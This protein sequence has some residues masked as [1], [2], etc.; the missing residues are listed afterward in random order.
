MMN[1]IVNASSEMPRA[2]LSALFG[3]GALFALF[4]GIYLGDQ[5]AEFSS[6]RIRIWKRA[7][8]ALGVTLI[9]CSAMMVIA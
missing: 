5:A 8:F 2:V 7:F 6:R 4:E 3:S 9:G 1:M